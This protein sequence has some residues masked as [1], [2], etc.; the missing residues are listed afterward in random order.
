VLLAFGLQGL[1]LLAA[2]AGPAAAS[3]SFS[4][5]LLLAGAG[6]GLW[7][8]RRY[9]GLPARM[10]RWAWLALGSW[11]LVALAF[12]AMGFRWVRGL[13]VPATLAVL[14]L[15]IAQELGRLGRAAEFRAPAQ[16]GAAVAAALALTALGAGVTAAFFPADSMAFSPQVRAWFCFAILGAHQFSTFLL[17]Q[18]QAQRLRGRL[19][20]LAG[21]DALT[22]LASAKGFWHRLDRA[23]GRSL[24]TGKPTSIMV[25][26]LDGYAA[27]LQEHGPAPL[28]RIEEAFASTMNRTLRE[29]D[30]SGRL[31]RHQF[32]ALLHQTQPF[33]ALLAAERLR[34]AWENVPLALGSRAIR[35]TLS[36][37]VASTVEPISGPEDLLA[38]AM[39]RAAAVS[40]GGGN[41][42]VG[43]EEPADA[44]H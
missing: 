33:Q 40:L 4:D 43:A 17:A 20:G 42:V 23:V 28:E 24:R 10:N 30:L 25:L 7:A 11:L 37:G 12:H 5:G 8:L 44:P 32:I 16:V 27:L 26:E 34:A 15:G 2:L 1:A 6:Y 38:L 9:A 14:A 18:V 31:E 36:A 39:A 13:A 21:V 22:G 29:A 41:N 19:E 35:V 3:T